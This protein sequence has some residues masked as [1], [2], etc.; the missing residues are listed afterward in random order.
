MKRSLTLLLSLLTVV[1]IAAPKSPESPSQVGALVARQLSLTVVQ[2]SM[3]ATKSTG[4][5]NA[6]VVTIKRQGEC[7]NGK[8]TLKTYFMGKEL[9][10]NQVVM[11]S[12]SEQT[13]ETKLG[14]GVTETLKS[15]PFVV[16]PEVP[17]TKKTKAIP[18]SGVR[19]HGWVVRVYQNDLLLATA[20]SG[21]GYEAVIAK[22]STH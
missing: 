5:V 3:P 7:S 22:A 6:L 4:K 13:V 19:P 18:A 16:T 15:D 9:E 20:S 12:M 8:V 1:A 14:P 2:S 17:A 11:H 21:Q 10:T